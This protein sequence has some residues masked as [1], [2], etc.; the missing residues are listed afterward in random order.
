MTKTRQNAILANPLLQ[1]IAYIYKSALCHHSLQ[2]NVT[3]NYLGSCR[4]AKLVTMFKHSNR[5]LSSGVRYC[6]PTNLLCFS[7]RAPECITV[8]HLENN[9]RRLL[10]YYV[11]KIYLKIRKSEMSK[12][13]K[14]KKSQ[15]KKV[16]NYQHHK[17]SKPTSINALYG[18]STVFF[19]GWIVASIVTMITSIF[20]TYEQN[21]ENCLFFSFR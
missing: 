6:S 17:V 8:V 13:F 9:S 3:S 2:I 21:T 20:L 1:A 10:C 18:F 5:L 12:S 14:K 4:E 19:G 15:L 7:L 11:R 16:K